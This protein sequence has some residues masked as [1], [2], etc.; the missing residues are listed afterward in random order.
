MY[1]IHHYVYSHFNLTLLFTLYLSHHVVI[2][3]NL[4]SF[5]L[6]TLFTSVFVYLLSHLFFY[7]FPCSNISAAAYLSFN[8]SYFSLSM[9]SL[10][11]NCSTPSLLKKKL[12]IFTLL[13]ILHHFIHIYHCFYVY[14]TL[15][16]PLFVFPAIFIPLLLC[17]LNKTTNFISM[18]TLPFILH[19]HFFHISTPFITHYCFHFYRRS[20]SFPI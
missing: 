20:K 14:G 8:H 3:L 11:Y 18:F 9:Y 16:F 4:V 7:Y 6:V 10:L 19:H 12:S 1:F 5:L 17:H 13:F 2:D 15:I